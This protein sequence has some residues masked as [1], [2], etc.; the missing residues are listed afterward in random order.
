MY[1]DHKK[2]QNMSPRMGAIRAMAIM[3]YIYH[4]TDNF[5]VRFLC[6]ITKLHHAPLRS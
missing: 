4:T 1:V 6:V 5:N 2:C 3:T